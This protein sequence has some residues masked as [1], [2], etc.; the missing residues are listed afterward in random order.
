MPRARCFIKSSGWSR[1]TSDSVSQ[2]AKRWTWSVGERRVLYRLPELLKYPDAT[3]FICE[4]EKDADRVAS[5]GHCATTVAGGKWTDD[6][7]TAL[8]GR[9][10]IILE[11]NDEAGRK[12]AREAAIALYAI[13]KTIRTVRLPGLPEKGDVSDWLDADPR[14]AEKLAEVC[15]A[16]PLWSPDL[17][18]PIA[19][20][21]GTGLHFARMNEVEAKHVEWLWLNRL[22]R[23]KLTLLAGD[24]GI[25]KSQISIDIAARA[26]KGATWPD[27]GH[28]PLGSVVILSAEDSANDTLR[29]PLKRPAPISNAFTCSQRLS[30]RVNR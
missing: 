4:G 20:A 25:G 23:G 30:L 16:A 27:G 2:T 22:A 11:D 19:A 5:L 8:A 18:A 28:A 9:D 1:R 15:F 6:C 7:V 10:C 14:N 21:T 24:P 3:A 17:A 13:A 26:S 29:P 12:K